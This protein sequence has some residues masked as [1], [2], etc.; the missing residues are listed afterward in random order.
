MRPLPPRSAGGGGGE[1]GGGGG[2]EKGGGGS[3]GGSP[4][5]AFASSK[6]ALF[7]TA[8]RLP[9]PPPARSSATH[10]AICGAATLVPP[11]GTREPLREPAASRPSRT[12]LSSLGATASG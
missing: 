10:R 5:G 4:S 11:T 12:E 6:V 1:K 7:C 3:G 8:V 9:F 2:G